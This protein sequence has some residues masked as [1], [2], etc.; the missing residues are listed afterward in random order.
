[1]NH[2]NRKKISDYII[3]FPFLW[4]FTGL[5][6]YP[7]GDKLIVLF[8]LLAAITSVCSYGI[9]SIFENIKKN[10]LLW[11]LGV[12][13]LLS[14]IAKVY[15]GYGSS[16]MRG[17]FS[18]FIFL[19]ILPPTLTEKI[20]LKYFIFIG[21]CTSFIYVMVQ[22]F[23]FDQGR[24]WSINPIPYATFIACLCILSFYYL[25]QSKLLKQ[26]VLWSFTFL[27]T[28][29]PLLYSQSR[30]LW[31][32]LTIMMLVVIAKAFFNRKSSIYL[33][34][35]FLLASSFASYFSQDKITNR[36]DHTKKEIHEIMTGNLNTSIG[37]R[38]QMWKAGWILS[39][40]SPIIGLGDAHVEYKKSLADKNIISSAIIKY[41]HY[42]NQYLNDFVKYGVIGLCLL[43]LSILLPF[44]YLKKYQTEYTWPGFL[45]IGIFVIA[46]LTDVPFQQSQPLIFYFAMMHVFLSHKRT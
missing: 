35:P 37:K 3:Y 32:A 23:I 1:M 28:I 19:A 20:N 30:G 17:L 6:S 33:I 36:I 24:A 5:F 41:A 34:I 7:N 46:S 26:I 29:I 25:L 10:K 40:Q 16:V 9:E 15:Y 14:I 39:K 12:H 27:L 13:S 42:H 38:F 43:L 8:V 21:A 44:Y 2:F 11:F 22:T 31:L 45:I 18:L 4:V